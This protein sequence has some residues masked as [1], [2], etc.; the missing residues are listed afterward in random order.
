MAK[1]TQ[2]LFSRAGMWDKLVRRHIPCFFKRGEDRLRDLAKRNHLCKALDEYKIRHGEVTI[3]SVDKQGHRRNQ[4][5][6]RS[7]G[8]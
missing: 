3:P 5:C 4:T 2:Q 8:D 7:P 1:F 6:P